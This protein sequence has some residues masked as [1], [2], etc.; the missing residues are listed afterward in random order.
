LI[1]TVLACVSVGADVL[2][3]PLPNIAGGFSTYQDCVLY[4][5][6]TLE[7]SMLR[8]VVHAVVDDLGYQICPTA[9][10]YPAEVCTLGFVFC[11]TVWKNLDSGISYEPNGYREQTQIGDY[12][13][14]IEWTCGNWGFTELVDGDVIRISFDIYREMMCRVPPAETSDPVV[15]L[16]S[17]TLLVEVP[18]N[19]STEQSTWGRVKDL[20]IRE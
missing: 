1:V 10:G 18:E 9:G 8:L 20:H 19:V 16:T 5:G 11:G 17:V 15:A 7:V 14:T 3:F 4:S 6:D 13:K 12:E 2:E